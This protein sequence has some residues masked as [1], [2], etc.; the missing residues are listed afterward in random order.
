MLVCIC[1]DKEG[2]G[3]DVTIFL[4]VF[5]YSIHFYCLVWFDPF[6]LETPFCLPFT[7][8]ETHL[9]SPPTSTVYNLNS[10]P[11]DHVDQPAQCYTTVVETMEP[12]KAREVPGSSDPSVTRVLSVGAIWA[13]HGRMDCGWLVNRTGRRG[14]DGLTSPFAWFFCFI[15]VFIHY[16]RL[17]G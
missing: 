6:P 13:R 17:A 14:R 16:C 8:S 11:S 2:R 7:L 9:V 12:Y 1:M 3:R 10:S 4:N 5:F 15:F